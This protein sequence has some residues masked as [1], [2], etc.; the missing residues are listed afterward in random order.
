MTVGAAYITSTPGQSAWLISEFGVAEGYL[1]SPNGQYWL[2]MQ[3]D[4]RLGLYKGTSPADRGDLQWS[5]NG[6]PKQGKWFLN[7]Q[8]DG[9]LAVWSGEP[10]VSAHWEPSYWSSGTP[11]GPGN[12]FLMVQDDGNVVVYRGTGP[13]DNRGA[14]WSRYT[15]RL[16]APAFENRIAL[17]RA[18][19]PLMPCTR[20]EWRQV[21]NA[22]LV[23]AKQ[24]ATLYLSL[25]KDLI[26]QVAIEIKSCAEEAAVAAALAAIFSGG[27]AAAGAAE[28]AFKQCLVRKG[29]A[30]HIVSA[31]Q[32]YVE[33]RCEW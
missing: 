17:A 10:M 7:M 18:D 8:N 4:G 32:L 24:T 23:E 31:V 33:T 12:Y 30:A 13:L 29:V 25:D 16:I 6:A 21:Y 11:F 20:W 28:S 9:N 1:V 5:E 27:A 3:G 2:I 14:L 22:T 15:G 26:N 19:L